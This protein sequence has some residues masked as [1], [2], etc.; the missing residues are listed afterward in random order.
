[1][2]LSNDILSGSSRRFHLWMIAGLVHLA[3][4][5]AGSFVGTDFPAV[6]GLYGYYS[7]SVSKLSFFAPGVGSQLRVLYHGLNESGITVE[8]SL[9]TGRGETDLRIAKI[10]ANFWRDHATDELRRA[11]AASWAGT[12]FG[13]NPNLVS[14]TITL[15]SYTFRRCA[16][17][18]RD[19]V[20]NG[21]PTTTPRSTRQG[22]PDEYFGD[23]VRK[24]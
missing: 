19:T 1:M 4:S 15:D 8:G 17:S 9:L 21:V 22:S 2:G 24:F 16:I 5:A 11:L 14:V 20:Q 6:L 18:G 7:G 12:V 13:K 10:V 23:E 3:I